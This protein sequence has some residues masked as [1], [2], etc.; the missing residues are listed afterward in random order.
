M[1]SSNSM[2][3]RTLIIRGDNL[4]SLP[5]VFRGKY[6]PEFA[7]WN[8]SEDVK[9]F[10]LEKFKLRQGFYLAVTV[11]FKYEGDDKCTVIVVVAGGRAGLLGLDIFGAEESLA[12]EI[13][14]FIRRVS[15]ERGWV[16]P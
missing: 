3:Q 14:D 9:V 16:C 1:M 15:R 8:N 12:R 13:S 2:K 7:W 4:E 11:I 6:S 10:V 5:G